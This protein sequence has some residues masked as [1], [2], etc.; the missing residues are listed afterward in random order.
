MTRILVCGLCPL[1]FENTRKSFG[2]GIRTWQF[3]LSLAAAGNEVHLVA[4]R[5]PG[6]YGDG[7]QAHPRTHPAVDLEADRREERDAVR[8]ERLVDAEFFDVAEIERRLAEIAPEAVVGATLYGSHM[9]ARCALDVPFWAD[10]FGHVMAEAQAKA[11]LERANWPLAHF[12]QL[13]APILRNADH[14]STVSH[15]QRWAAIGELGVIGRLTAENCGHELLSVIPCALIP[16]S[17][18]AAPEPLLRGSRLPDDAFVVL[19]SGGYNVWSDVETLFAAL[20]TAM[21]GAER[22]HFVSTGGE[23]AGHDEVTYRRF[24]DLVAGSRF[25]ARYHLEGWV[26]AELVPRYQAD[27]DLGVLTEIA[28]AEGQLGHKNRIVQWLGA[29]LPVAYNLVGDLGELLERERI[30][31]TFPVGSAAGLADAMV[32][33][34]ANPE[35]LRAMA[36]AGRVYVERELTFE[37]TTRELVDWAAA[38]AFAPDVEV[39]RGVASPIDFALKPAAPEPQPETAPALEPEP[40]AIEAHVAAPEVV[41]PPPPPKR[42]FAYRVARAVYRRVK[43]LALRL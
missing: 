37:R 21:A 19:W 42:S 39:R 31:L 15:R 14:F 36:D 25:S 9:L 33:A 43:A 7:S 40:P 41:P 13:L 23:I 3:A 24:C 32:W 4:M 16:A 22:L 29:G 12:W 34:M 11:F 8:I 28:M 2:P 1:P 18:S 10:Q 27:A 20:E 6:T 26:P 5:I 38:P 35:E 17:P 30:G